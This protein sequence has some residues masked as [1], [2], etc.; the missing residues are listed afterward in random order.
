MPRMKVHMAAYVLPLSIAALAIP[1]VLRRV[2]PNGLYGFRTTKTLSSTEAWYKA[3]HVSGLYMLAAAVLSMMFN[4][5]LWTQIRLAGIEARVL[6]GE[7][8][9]CVCSCGADFLHPLSSKIV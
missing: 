3:N 6:D 1:M 2:P 7:Q 8:H 9:R 5:L 4:L